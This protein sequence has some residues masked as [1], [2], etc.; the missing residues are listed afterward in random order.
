MQ[1]N[2]FFHQVDADREEDDI[3]TDIK[4]IVKDKLFSKE[5]GNGFKSYLLQYYLFEV[6]KS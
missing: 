3:F 4:A 5:E 2:H 6:K 1:I